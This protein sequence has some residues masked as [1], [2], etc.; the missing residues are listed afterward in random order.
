M[1]LLCYF[2]LIHGKVLQR[3]MDIESTILSFIHYNQTFLRS[4]ISTLQF[5]SYHAFPTTKV[6]ARKL[7]V[8]Q[9]DLG[10]VSFYYAMMD[11]FIQLNFVFQRTSTFTGMLNQ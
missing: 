6:T 4:D 10:F 1:T 3:M 11:L 5:K 9:F 2:S 7:P 8:L